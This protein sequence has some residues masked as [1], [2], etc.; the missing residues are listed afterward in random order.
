MDC[1]AVCTEGDCVVLLQDAVYS[2]LATSPVAASLLAA[3]QCGVKLFA[4]DDDCQARH[5]TPVSQI[6]AIN[7]DDFVQLSV[8]CKNSQSWV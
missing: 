7:Y 5:I 6:T 3:H 8:D 4:L 2:T 1:L